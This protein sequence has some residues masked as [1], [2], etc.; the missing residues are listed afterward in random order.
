MAAGS[1]GTKVITLGI[2]K[3]INVTELKIIASPP[4]EKNYIYVD[5]FDKLPSVEQELKDDTCEGTNM[6]CAEPVCVSLR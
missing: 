2:A 4:A 5:S 3:E 1:T 6:C